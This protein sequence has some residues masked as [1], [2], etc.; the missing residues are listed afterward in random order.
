MVLSKQRS[1]ATSPAR[2][3]HSNQRSV[4]STTP[5]TVISN[6]AFVA[7]NAQWLRA[8]REQWLCNALSKQRQSGFQ[9][10]C[11]SGSTMASNRAF[12]VAAQWL[13]LCF[14]S[15]VQYRRTMISSVQWLR[16]VLWE[17]RW[18]ERS[19][20]KDRRIRESKIS[21]P[22]EVS[23]QNYCIEIGKGLQ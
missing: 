6:G 3:M 11:R 18:V 23:F 7:I 22:A 14:R 20:R 5:R 4:A 13:K 16:I 15:S 2:A 1:V 21:R 17:Q 12:E 8:Q 9:V 10:R 19:A